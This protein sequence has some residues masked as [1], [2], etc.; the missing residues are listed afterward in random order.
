MM[1]NV[2]SVLKFL[3]S[4]ERDKTGDAWTTGSEIHD[5]L[6]G[7]T[8]ITPADINDAIN[9][10]RNRGWVKWMQALGTSP[11]DFA[12]VTITSEGRLRIED[13]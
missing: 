12:R 3:A 13:A 6:K 9:L 2:M 8:G 11:Y 10:S 1:D 5:G 4:R 7:R